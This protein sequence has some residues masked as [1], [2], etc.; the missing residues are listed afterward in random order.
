[1]QNV[2]HQHPAITPRLYRRKFGAAQLWFIYGFI[3]ALLLSSCAMPHKIN[4]EFLR[5]GTEIKELELLNPMLC[6]PHEY[7]K[8]LAY[9]EFANDA[10][11]EK[12]FLDAQIYLDIV[13]ENLTKAFKYVRYCRSAHPEAF[14]VRDEIP[15]S[16]PE[17]Q[18][19]S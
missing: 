8:I 7:A 10:F 4:D 11:A 18:Q 12:D 14:P 9:L 1:M 6:T 17:P 13:D 16:P 3:P 2:F 15:P 19:D 5:L